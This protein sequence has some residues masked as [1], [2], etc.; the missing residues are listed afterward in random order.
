MALISHLPRSALAA[1]NEH[2]V[3]Y[4]VPRNVFEIERTDTSALMRSL[5][6]QREAAGTAAR[7]DVPVRKA[8][9]FKSDE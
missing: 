9:D 3:V 1:A 2:G 4:L 8:I 5:I 6:A 7:P